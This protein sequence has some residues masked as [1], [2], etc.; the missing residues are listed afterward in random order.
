[1]GTESR[2][3][4]GGVLVLALVGVGGTAWA[5]EA[6]QKAPPLEVGTWI[7]GA[8]VNLASGAD[9]TVYVVEFW[10]T[11][12]GPCKESIPHLSALQRRFASEG[13]V[14]IGISDETADE[15]K[16]WI[17]AGEKDME[18]DMAYTVAV[19]DNDKTRT[20]YR[21]T[22]DSQGIPH[23]YVIDKK[24]VVAWHGHPMDG[25]DRV[26]ELVVAGQFD[27]KVQAQKQAVRERAI[28][29]LRQGDAE[30]GLKALDELIAL[31]RQDRSGYEIKASVLGYVGRAEEARQMRAS[32]SEVF[33]DHPLVLTD[34]AAEFASAEDLANRDP[35]QALA[36]ASR[37]VELT[38]GA[39]AAA[40]GALARAQYA[41]CL[42]D[43]AIASQEKA[44]TA[45]VGP[46]NKK[47]AQAVLD[48][49]RKVKADA[50]KG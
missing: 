48:Y 2:V 43:R 40:L 5:V 30:N 16:S 50:L 31:D 3:V 23:A 14:I 25:M 26:L 11:W 9:K 7:K 4:L 27:P 8:P 38:K 44:L 29:A 35:A 17:A 6:G 28:A 1:M 13:V 32:M 39:D 36:L 18:L 46:V 45:A 22:R 20:A 37:A 21:T 49:Y 15:V 33:K 19:D 47:K 42:I 34:L 12:C 41:L 10:A 24:G